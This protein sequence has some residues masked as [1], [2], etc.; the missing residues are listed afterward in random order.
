MTGRVEWPVFG[1]RS[2]LRAA[3]EGRGPMPAAGAAFAVVWLIGLDAIVIG[4]LL[5]IL[6]L[7][8]RSVRQPDR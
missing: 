8:L 5:L 3:G 4:V 2:T 1:G 7:R 6:G